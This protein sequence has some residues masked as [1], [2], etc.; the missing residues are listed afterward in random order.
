MI[1]NGNKTQVAFP[2]YPIENAPNIDYRYGPYQSMAAALQALGPN[3]LDCIVPGLRFGILAEDGSV[4]DY[5]FTAL[6]GEA[7][8]VDG[9]QAGSAAA[10]EALEVAQQAQTDAAQAKADAASAAAHAA[11]ADTVAGNAMDLA[12]ETAATL[13]TVQQATAQAQSTATNAQASAVQAQQ[14]ATNAQA[15]A[16]SAVETAAQAMEVAQQAQQ[17]AGS[18]FYGYFAS[19]ADLPQGVTA[20]GYA[21]VG[22]QSP[23]EVWNFDGTSWSDSGTT[24][25][26]GDVQVDNEDLAENASGL[27]QFKDRGTSY[28]SKGYVRVRKNL[29]TASVKKTYDS[30]TYIH[31]VETTHRTASTATSAASYNAE[32]QYFDGNP[33][34]LYGNGSGFPQAG[35]ASVRKSVPFVVL[36]TT[37]NKVYFRWQW[38]KGSWA[39]ADI[40]YNAWGEQPSSMDF[41]V[42]SGTAKTFAYVERGVTHYIHWTGSAWQTDATESSEISLLASNAFNQQDT[43]YEIMYDMDLNGGTITPAAGVVLKYAGGKIKNGI[44]DCSN[45]GI[46]IDCPDVQFFDGVRFL[47]MDTHVMKDVWFDDIW[48]AMS[49]YAEGKSPMKAISLSRDYTLDHRYCEFYFK[50]ERVSTGARKMKFTIWGNGHTVKIDTSF[51]YSGKTFFTGRY[52]EAHDLTINVTNTDLQVFNAIFNIKHADFWNVHYKGYSRLIANWLGDSANDTDTAII[53]HGCSVKVSSFAFEHY[54]FKIELTDTEVSYINPSDHQYYEIMSVGTYVSSARIFNNI[55]RGHIEFR[56][57]KI[58]GPIEILDNYGITTDSKDDAGAAYST[59]TSSIKT[60][61][62]YNYIHAYDCE[63]VRFGFSNSSV[64]AKGMMKVKFERCNMTVGYGPKGY[65]R[66]DTVEFVDCFITA[67]NDNQAANQVGAFGFEG[68]NSATFR[69]CTI[70]NASYFDKDTTKKDGTSYPNGY[71]YEPMGT[72]KCFL[73]YIPAKADVIRQSSDAADTYFASGATCKFHLYMY[74]NTI[75]PDPSSPNFFHIR[76]ISPYGENG[77]VLAGETVATVDGQKVYTNN[78][79]DTVGLGIVREMFVMKGNRIAYGIA[80]KDELGCHVWLNRK[81]NVMPVDGTVFTAAVAYGS[82][83]YADS[84]FR[85]CNVDFKFMVL[86]ATS[87]QYGLFNAATRKVSWQ[88]YG[89]ENSLPNE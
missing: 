49:A 29:V 78:P 56:R 83:R 11:N 7:I 81:V 62:S 9:D 42:E 39:Y 77:T 46:V 13:T 64:R 12:N 58:G 67:I 2:V 22:T 15:S 61:Y 66:M 51:I 8:P 86:T 19:S 89:S 1:G 37:D 6:T 18:G 68:V 31:G 44:I 5:K 21:C 17:A 69:G 40:Y 34:S 80:T 71:K 55:E 53:M 30:V 85:Y 26:K 41:T 32:S 65:T 59:N 20:I 27:V 57:C 3:G 43:V 74:G 38:N 47:N 28:S 25:S 72:G 23:Y 33:T 50:D 10:A 84:F 70:S 79:S 36:N 88:T 52:V 73:S 87:P 76:L 48:L 63:L 4:T 16:S 14:T 75:I 45:G 82:T 24:M 35:N 60:Y 54:F